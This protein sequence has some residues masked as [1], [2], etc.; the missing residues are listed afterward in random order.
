MLFL[1][2]HHKEDAMLQFRCTIIMF[3]WLLMLGPKASLL[4]CG[5]YFLLW[6]SLDSVSLVLVACYVSFLSV[7]GL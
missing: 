3:H 6:I 5:Q 7:T 4:D 1:S 2:S